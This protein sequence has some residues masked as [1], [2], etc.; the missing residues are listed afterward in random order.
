MRDIKE[1]GQRTLQFEDYIR[2]SDEMDPAYV[3]KWHAQGLDKQVMERNDFYHRW[4]LFTPVSS[5]EKSSRRYPLLFVLHGS[6]MPINWEECSGFLPIAARD[7]IIFLSHRRSLR[8]SEKK[9]AVP[10]CVS[11]SL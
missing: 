9:I 3:Q 1:G 4:A 2:Y 5:R 11:P 8:Q 10:S 6:S 7:P